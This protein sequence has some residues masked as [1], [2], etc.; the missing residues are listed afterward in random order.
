MSRI[1]LIPVSV[2][3]KNILNGND[4]GYRFHTTYLKLNSVKAFLRKCYLFAIAIGPQ[5]T[6]LS[7][8]SMMPCPCETF[9]LAIEQINK[10]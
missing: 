8:V 3:L 2:I 4:K 9:S 7:K 10:E 5:A 6:S 1:K